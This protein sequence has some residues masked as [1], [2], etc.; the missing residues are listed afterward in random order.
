VSFG[1]LNLI[2]TGFDYCKPIVQV[3]GT[4]L[5]GKYHG[6][7]LTV[8]SQDG[9]RNI[10]PLAFEIVEGETKEAM[11]WFFQLLCAHVT[12]QPNVCLITD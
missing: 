7:L 5:T 1:L 6:T 8:I 4:F 12:P 3:D 2:L 10:C 9:N 11:I